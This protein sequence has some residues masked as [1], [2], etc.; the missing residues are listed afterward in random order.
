MIAQERQT[1]IQEIIENTVTNGIGYRDITRTQ[2]RPRPDDVILVQYDL[3]DM[4]EHSI[5]RTLVFDSNLPS[6][7][8][9]HSLF[10]RSLTK[11][12]LHDNLPM[13]LRQ[14]EM[15]LKVLNKLH[16]LGQNFDNLSYAESVKELA[17]LMNQDRRFREALMDD[18][19]FFAP[20]LL[21]A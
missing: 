20:T 12:G 7:T 5:G 15:E 11:C 4:L 18:I 19:T 3:G 6:K 1:F 16:V 21:S 13:A 8:Q 10:D 17:K 9:R 14:I 2:P